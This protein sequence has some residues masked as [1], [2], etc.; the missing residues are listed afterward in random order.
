VQLEPYLFF[1]GDCEAALNF[2]AKAIGGEITTLMRMSEAP[3]E[4]KVSPADAQLVMHATFK[5]NGISF[6]ASDGN[7]ATKSKES[8]I[9]LSV[10]ADSDADAQRLFNALS[11]G[12]KVTMPFTDAFWGG[13][14]GSLTDK[15][16]MDWFIA[17]PH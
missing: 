9:T 11:A 3:A 5:G 2:Y 6:M 16:G 15:Y 7:P 12:G 14:F 10:S 8:N 17:S 1:Y 4:M 13:K